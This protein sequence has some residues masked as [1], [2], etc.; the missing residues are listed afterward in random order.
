MWNLASNAKSQKIRMFLAVVFMLLLVIASKTKAE[1]PNSYYEYSQADMKAG[2]MKNLAIQYL[3]TLSERT[4]GESVTSKSSLYFVDVLPIYDII[5]GECYFPSGRNIFKIPQDRFQSLESVG[6]DSP[7]VAAY[8]TIYYTSS[9]NRK[10]NIQLVSSLVD[11]FVLPPGKTFS[12]NQ[13]TGPRGE[14]QGYLEAPVISRGEFV[15]DYG[16]GVCQVS[17]TIYAAIQQVPGFAVTNREP[18]GLEVT[19]LP[20]GM[21]ATVNYGSIDFKFLNKYPFTVQLHVKAEK[22]VCLVTI[23]RVDD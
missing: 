12:F 20:V 19:Y 4:A 18:H 15:D 13:V 10:H 3:G 22:D 7:I 16:G 9:A 6:K 17:S 21:D 5:D 11:G 2:N 1:T 23:T 8:R 14:R